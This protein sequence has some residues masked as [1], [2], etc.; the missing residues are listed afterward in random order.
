MSTTRDLL[1]GLAQ[2]SAAASLG[3]YRND[4]SVFT[5]SDTG[6]GI[7][8][9]PADPARFICLTPYGA[10]GDHP[11]I[12]MGEQRI[13]VRFRGTTDPDDVDDLADALFTVW[14]G[15]TNLTF[16]SVR[17]LQILRISSLPL[18]MDDQSRR[19]MR[20]DNYALDLDYPTSPNRPI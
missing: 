9:M 12:P 19:W 11:V 18:G 3:V 10:N 7:K 14:H 6:I 4:G 2:W 13:Q 16:G 17:V 8:A 1:T 5:D 20:S 15:A